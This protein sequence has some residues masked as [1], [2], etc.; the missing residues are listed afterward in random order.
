MGIEAT[1][2]SRAARATTSSA[3]RD[4]LRLTEA[5]HMRSLAGGLP[6]PDCLPVDRI[7]E[8]TTVVLRR[9]GARALQYAPT[10]GIAELR[11][12]AAPRVLAETEQTI[13][14][15]GSQQGLDLVVRT[16]V[17][18]GDVVVVESPS[19]LGA[20]QVLTAAGAHVVAIPGDREGLRTDLLA[21]RLA[22]GLRP[23]LL[24][25]VSEF[26]N[27]TGATLATPRRVEL[28]ALAQRYG[29]VVVEDD[30]YGALRYRGEAGPSLRSFAPE[31]VV[32]LGSASKVLAP[33]L[34]V[35]WLG[36][37]AWLAGALVR[38]K[39]AADLHTSTLDQLLVIELL[40]DTAWFANHV[41]G[42]VAFYG[43]RAE[44]LVGLLRRHLDG[45]VEASVP[46][47]G[48][49]VWARTL[50]DGVDTAALLPTAVD[51]GVAYVPGAAF[52]VDGGGTDRLR[53][54]FTTLDAAGLEEA[55]Q[56]LATAFTAAGSG[57]IRC[58]GVGAQKPLGLS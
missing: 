14:T 10:E 38:A 11:A 40:T 5:P 46:D 35:G 49:F 25:V 23:R 13:V 50:D 45:V 56:R 8:A 58:H 27:P 2:L 54:C 18:P 44:L 29:F 36:A 53:L 37:P 12:L 41:A 20:I 30:P 34:R 48:M 16:L 21:G 39:Q 19:Y 26:A 28:A 1:T 32:R 31:H 22:A 3:I 33:G 57:A 24:Y 47:G 7:A 9:H 6:A 52:H 17:D 4:L 51:A 15:T 42:L 43:A 55:C